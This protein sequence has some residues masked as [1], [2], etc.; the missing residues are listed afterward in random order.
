MGIIRRRF[1]ES[2]NSGDGEG[3]ISYI[4]VRINYL[5]FLRKGGGA[6]YSLLPSIVIETFS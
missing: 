6:I 3:W 1:F 4:V 5:A 2:S